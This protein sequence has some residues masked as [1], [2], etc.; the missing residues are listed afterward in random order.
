MTRLIRKTHLYL[1]LALFPWVIMYA[2]S[3][4]VMNHRSFFRREEMGKPQALR[5]VVR[6]EYRA[7]LTTD[8]SPDEVAQKILKDLEMEGKFRVERSKEEHRMVI[9]RE[10]PWRPKK[11]TY[12]RD[13]EVLIVE[14]PPFRL[15]NFIIGLH[16]KSGYG[17]DYLTP[18][19]WAAIVDIFSV[20]MIAWV[21]S[22]IYMWWGLSRTRLWGGLSL[23]RRGKHRFPRPRPGSL[24]D[25]SVTER[26]SCSA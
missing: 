12:L 8:V 17:G 19:I 24:V 4:F 6:M 5:E 22:G 26:N 3:T 10:S 25:F 7:A 16:H 2:A 14:E 13:Q 9:R 18:I 15:I 21:A 23:A 11:I 20:A 1:A